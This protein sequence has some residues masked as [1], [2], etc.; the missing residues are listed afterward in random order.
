MA[1]RIVVVRSGVVEQIGRPLELY[2]RPA[3]LF[4]A[5][6]IGSPAMNLIK[7]K[8]SSGGFVSEGGVVLP[9]PAGEVGGA[10]TYGLRPEHLTL[11]DAGFRAEVVVVEP[12]GAETQV[13]A[14]CGGQTLVAVLRER[15]DLNPGDSIGLK[16]ELSA[17]HLFGEDGRRIQQI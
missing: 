15:V 10:A 7:G 2:D 8:A 3:N 12:T 6:F 17:V 4:V 11:D 1:G 14:R 5:T 16:P 13:L 9:L